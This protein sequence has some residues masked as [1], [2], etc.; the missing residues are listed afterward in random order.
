MT[1]FVME[2]GLNP[3]FVKDMHDG[4]QAGYAIRKMRISAAA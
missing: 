2:T 4:T 3:L 1:T